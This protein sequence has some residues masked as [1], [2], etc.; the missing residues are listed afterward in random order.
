MGLGRL[1]VRVSFRVLPAG[2]GKES[3]RVL[4]WLRDG[5]SPGDWVK[6]VP[7]P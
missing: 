4:A 7:R 5:L 3:I 6:H 2:L 1:V